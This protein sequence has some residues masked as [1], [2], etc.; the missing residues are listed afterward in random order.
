MSGRSSFIAALY[1]ASQHHRIVAPEHD[2]ERLRTT[3]G[4]VADLYDRARPTYPGAVY[5]DLAEAGGIQPG[6]RILELGPGTGKAT[7]EL[8]RRGYEVV[9]VELSP[10]LAAVARR[11]LEAYPRAEVVTADFETWEGR[12]GSFDAVVAFTSF[13][14]LDPDVRFARAA[15]LLRERGALGVIQTNHVLPGEG[16]D[17]FW[18]EIQDVYDEV[19]PHP[20]NRPPPLPEEI[21][22]PTAEVVASGL[23]DDVVERRHLWT[24]AYGPEYVEVLGTYSSNI[25]LP[26]E[27]REEL[28]RRIAERIEARPG[29]RVTKHYLAT[30]TVGRLVTKP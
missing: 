19:V 7:I 6:G 11:N 10:D 29:G 15:G 24:Q 18:E 8:A 27:Q 23:F 17:S 2:R 12:P 3:F 20:D 26:A 13:H 25:A 22:G 28:F 9:A 4:T 14:W 1:S 21:R 30:L 16:G 5:D